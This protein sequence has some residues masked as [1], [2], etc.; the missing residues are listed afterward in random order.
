MVHLSQSVFSLRRALRGSQPIPTQS[1]RGIF[2]YD[3][4]QTVPL[5]QREL[6]ANVA[7][8]GRPDQRGNPWFLVLADAIGKGEKKEQS[9]PHERPLTQAD[10]F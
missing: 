6:G 4:S 7:I 1:L 2:S 5:S 3:K 10:W 9:Y 8:Q